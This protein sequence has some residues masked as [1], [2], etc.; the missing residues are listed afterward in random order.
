[1]AMKRPDSGDIRVALINRR[2]P[3]SG[4]DHLA[5]Q[6]VALVQQAQQ[7][8]Q[9]DHVAEPAEKEDRGSSGCRDFQ[10][11]SHVV[12]WH[13]LI[14]VLIIAALCNER[15]PTEPMARRAPNSQP[16]AP[17]DTSTAGSRSN[18]I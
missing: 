9:H 14:F 2:S 7:R 15:S 13:Q 18:L 10:C 16:S 6:A 11:G 12:R 3:G 1:M 5:R 17:L 4:A 8:G